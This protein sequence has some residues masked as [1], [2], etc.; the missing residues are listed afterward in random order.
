M[1]SSLPNFSGKVI[2]IT[3]GASGIGLS[4]A[5]LLS[6][7]G[8]TVSIGDLTAAGLA[9]AEQEIAAAGGKVFTKVID[10]RKRATVDAWIKETVE[11]FGQLDGA[12]NMAGV[13]GKNHGKG[14]VSFMNPF[15]YFKKGGA[16]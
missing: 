1:T 11:K 2:A 7:L 13:I 16:V 3:G 5:K 14:L 9:S 6:S 10:V 8:A 12:A 4:C 15:S